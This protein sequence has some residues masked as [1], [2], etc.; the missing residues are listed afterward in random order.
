MNQSNVGTGRSNRNKS[1]G[2]GSSPSSPARLPSSNVQETS[3]PRSSRNVG[4]LRSASDL[5][6][7]M[8]VPTTVSPP[9]AIPRAILPDNSTL[10]AQLLTGS[11]QPGA[12]STT[13]VL[14]ADSST[15]R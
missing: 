10:L 3:L 8:P 9:A 7:I 6:P 14:T 2:T 11:N 4:R 13:L 1:G 5:H 15:P 12:S